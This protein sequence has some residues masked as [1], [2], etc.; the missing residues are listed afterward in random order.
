MAARAV[1]ALQINEGSCWELMTVS[2]IEAID[3]IFG[4]IPSILCEVSI[5]LHL[6]VQQPSAPD[7]AMVW[8]FSNTWLDPFDSHLTMQ[9]AYW[10]R[11]ASDSGLKSISNDSSIDKPVQAH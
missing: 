5:L 7:I 10:K 1:Y 3:K 4:R 9:K 8:L 6:S 2:S 11:D